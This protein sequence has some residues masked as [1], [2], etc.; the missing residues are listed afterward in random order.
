M[1]HRFSELGERPKSNFSVDR[2]T[3]L[4][5]ALPTSLWDFR[6]VASFETTAPQRPKFGHV[7]KYWS[8]CKNLGEGSAK[9]PS[10]NEVQSSSLK[11]QL[12]V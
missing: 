1:I 8:P 10:H 2:S 3:G 9:C 4:S 5:S 6:F 12:L 7:S 11:M